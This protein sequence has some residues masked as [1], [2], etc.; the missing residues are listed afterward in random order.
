MQQSYPARAGTQRQQAYARIWWHKLVSFWAQPYVWL[1]CQVV[2]VLGVFFV[3]P[4]AT[5]IR[6]SFYTQVTGVGMQP[7]FTLENFAK[8]FQHELY[9]QVLAKTLWN[10]LLTTL[11]ALVLGYPVAYVIA[12]GHPLVRRILIIAVI[13]PL[14]VG[15]VIRT[16]GWMVLL[17]RKGLINQ[18]LGAIGL[19]DRPLR[20]TG[21]DTGVIISLLHVFYPFMVLPLASVL[22]KIER[23]LEEAAMILGANRFQVFW[24]V[25]LPLSLPGVAAGSLMVFILTA[26]S[27]VT[28]RLI[29][30]NLTKWLLALVE[31]QILT[32]FDWPFGAAMAVIFIAVVLLLITAYWRALESKFAFMLR[33]KD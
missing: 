25:I 26:G 32:V 28:P 27:F 30:Q 9:R 10:A 20:L 3:L 6:Y 18:L 8:L 14:L 24:R 33:E 17:S 11:I 13:S 21:N 23:P 15:I 7:D 19:I 1:L 31:E 2:L 5:M 12:R 4:L 22:Q 16:Y 29:G